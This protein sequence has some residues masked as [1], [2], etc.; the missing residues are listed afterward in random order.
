MRRSIP[1]VSGQYYHIYNRGNNKQKIFLEEKNYRFFLSRLHHYLDT[2]S[3]G[4]CGYC[5]MPNHY[6]L[7][8]YLNKSVDFSKVMQSLSIS[9]VK[10]FNRW[11][12]RVGHLFQSDFNVKQIDDNNYLANVCGYIHLNP[13]MAGLVFLP[14]EWS[15]S[16]YAEWL[17]SSD[18]T[19]P[20]VR[21]RNQL[22]RDG[23]AYK[24]FVQ[25]MLNEKKK[26]QEIEKSLVRQRY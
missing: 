10:S 19:M 18:T 12:K 15:F 8:V 22:F 11:H 21:L 5:L 2:A 17:N 26:Q 20:Q 1:F 23:D 4:L 14:Q 13:V 7:L 6:H 25:Y 24:I 16:D 3:V 9:Y